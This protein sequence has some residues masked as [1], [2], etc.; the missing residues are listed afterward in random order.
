MKVYQCDSCK[1]TITDPYE[2]RMKE[3]RVACHFDPQHGVL[4]MH[5]KRKR[6]VHLCKDC[7]YGLHYLAEKIKEST[8]E[9][10]VEE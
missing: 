1:K 7:F 10:E 9:N 3:F 8:V 4:P 5:D 6:T 2:E